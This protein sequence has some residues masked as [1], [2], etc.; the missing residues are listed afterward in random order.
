MKELNLSTLSV[1]AWALAKDPEATFIYSSNRHCFFAQ[2]LK[3][4]C[5]LDAWVTST[6]FWPIDHIRNVQ[7]IPDQVHTALD[8]ALDAT[9]TSIQ[10]K[11]IRYHLVAQYLER[12]IA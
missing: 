1:I 2:Y 8:L 7:E 6:S 9:P 10:G 5:G 4:V 11:L 12:A 3:E